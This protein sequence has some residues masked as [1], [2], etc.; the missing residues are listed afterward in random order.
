MSLLWYVNRLRSMPPRELAHRAQEAAKRRTARGRLEGWDRYAVP[1]GPLP[2]LAGLHEAVTRGCDARA[3]QA[4]ATASRDILAGRFSALGVAWP[5]RPP[6]DLFPPALW[7]FDPVSGDLWPGPERYCYDIPYR[8]RRDFGDVKYVWE[9]NRLQILQP[10]SA[11]VALTGDAASLAAVERAIESW[12]EANPPFRGLGWTSGIELAL[13]SI[14]LL[15]AASLCGD[16]LSSATVGR[17]RTLLNAHAFWLKR[18]PSRFSSANNHLIA[19]AAGEFLIGTAAPDLTGAADL[20]SGARR[21]LEAEACRQLLPDGVPGE[22]SPTYGAFTAEF[23]LL[24]HF[25]AAKAGRPLSAGVSHRLAAFADFVR[26]LA[27]ARGGVPSIG[28]DDEGRVLTT[29]PHE[30]TYATSVAS[31]IDALLGTAGTGRDLAEQDLRTTVFGASRSPA[32]PEDGVRTFERGGYSVVR[33]RRS[34]RSTILVF[35]HGPLGYLSIAAHGHAD[36]LALTLTIDDRPVLID[37]GTY[38]YHAGGAWRDWF[39]GTAA[40][41]TLTLG[42]AD[43]SIISGPFNWSHKAQARLEASHPGPDWTLRASH[44]GFV[45]RFGVRHE[46]TLS[47]TAEGYRVVDRLVGPL[48]AERPV[49]SFLTAPDCTVSPCGPGVLVSAG[50]RPVLEIR[51]DLGS[52]VVETGGERRGWASPAFGHKVPAAAIRWQA[53]EAT[54]Q[55]A[56]ALTLR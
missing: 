37:A 23:L 27:D 14:S 43:Q 5:D 17:I 11:H 53:R 34:G 33:E 42:D 1:E 29:A 18:F 52:L 39:R 46:R 9:V 8:H 45:S 21:V 47:A 10:L 41:N 51:A 50:G 6:A 2:R 13:R 28:D 35:D 48:P 22:Q 15:V 44:D 40:H 49:V 7:R 38:L 30:T 31:C 16:A 19:E 54:D 25:V 12:F 56:F 26:C 24:S 36:A 55:V 32:P 4:I 20:A 3:R